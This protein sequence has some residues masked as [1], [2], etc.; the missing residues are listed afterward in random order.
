MS[1][2]ATIFI[3]AFILLVSASV[4]FSQSSE[5]KDSRLDQKVTIKALGMPL[6][7]FLAE[8]SRQTG[9]RMTARR[10]IA[11]D[12]IAL[13]VKDLPLADLQEAIKEVLRV[14][15]SRDVKDGEPRY[16]FWMDLRT[17]QEIADA[18]NEEFVQ[19]RKRME[20]LV[21]DL[22]LSPEELEVKYKDEPH[23]LGNLKYERGRAA[24]ESFTALKDCGDL[25]RFGRQTISGSDLSS[26]LTAKLL[27]VLQPPK[28]SPDQ[29]PQL[30][31]VEKIVWTVGEQMPG[32]SKMLYCEIHPRISTGDPA[33]RMFSTHKIPFP[34]KPPVIRRDTANLEPAPDSSGPL[35]SYKPEEEVTV[36][37]TLCDIAELAGT[38]IV[39]DYFT[40]L[41]VTKFLPGEFAESEPLERLLTYLANRMDYEIADRNG[42]TL[43]V[44][45]D[46]R[47]LK[48]REIPERLVKA[49]RVSSEEIGW[50]GMQVAIEMAQLRP[51]QIKDLPLYHFRAGQIQEN[52][53][54]LRFLGALNPHQRTQAMSQQGLSIATLDSNQKEWLMA[55]A[56]GIGTGFLQDEPEAAQFYE[57]VSMRSSEIRLH[58]DAAP[59]EAALSAPDPLNGTFL[60]RT[61]WQK[62]GEQAY[63][64]WLFD[65][66]GGGVE[67]TGLRITLPL[68]KT[69]FSLPIRLPAGPDGPQLL[70][71][72]AVIE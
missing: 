12:K 41:T 13:Y 39:S 45:R 72:P 68:A 2:T 5:T 62:T 38:N 24:L 34:L 71:V 40:C 11:D 67:M 44:N 8:L 64:T 4:G 10:D 26:E 30:I 27:R 35:V 21:A 50:K 48:P 29:E 17:K 70:M 60:I 23:A 20:E 15:C 6:G 43:F 61:S 32:P 69:A 36:Y 42:A 28:I 47:R 52:V 31:G 66:L 54:L 19:L 1:K 51:E 9:V 56:N 55:W 65:V 49:W 3:T 14:R 57:S 33:Q 58:G 53:G 22:T 37:R 16:E 63:E 46:W 59:E 7:D 18:A 25:F